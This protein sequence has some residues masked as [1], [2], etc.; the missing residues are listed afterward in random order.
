[1][2]AEP[3]LGAVFDASPNA[4]MVLDR[5]LRYVAVNRAY[6][7]VTEH[8]REQLIG[9]C[10][11]D[12][13][14]HDPA[15]PSNDSAR[16]LVGSLRRVFD[17]GERDV[18]PTIHYRIAIGGVAQDRYWSASHTPLFDGAGRVEYVLQHT[19]DITELHHDRQPGSAAA[20]IQRAEAVQE[21]NRWLHDAFVQAP[22]ALVILRG[23]HHVVEVVNERT[24][25]MWGRTRDQV[26]DRPLFDAL[27]ELA[28]QG[29]RE[30]LDTVWRTRQPYVG[31]EVPIELVRGGNRERLHVT[32]VYQPMFAADGTVDSVIV[33]AVDV[34]QE[35]LARRKVEAAQAELQAIF[36][37]FP[38]ALYAGNA[39]GITRVNDRARE[40]FGYA[41]VDDVKRPFTAVAG[42]VVPRSPETGE[43]LAV[44]ELPFARAL[45][46]LATRRELVLTRADTREDRNVYVSSAPVLVE[47][48]ATGAVVAQIDITEHK[49]SEDEVHKLASV[50]DVTHD[51]VG[52]ADLSGTPT[53]VNA[54]GLALMGLP[55]L[56]AARALKVVEY[57]VPAERA[58]VRDEVLATARRGSYWE[59]ELTFQHARTGEPIPVLQ[60]A[61]PLRDRTGAVVALATVTRDLRAQKLAEAERARLLDAERAARAQAEAAN[62]AK[63]QF[64]AT[65][66]HELRTPLTA[67][68]GWM[69]MLRTGMVAPE[70]QQRALDTVERN[71]RIQAQL[72]DDLLDV[73]R[74]LAG[75]LELDLE[76]VELA[77][78]VAAAVETVRP[79]ADAKGLGIEITV[80]ATPPL[81]GDARRLQQVVWNLLSNAVKFTPRGGLV[82]LRVERGDASSVLTVTDTGAGIAPELLPHVFERFRQADNPSTR[83]AGGLGLGLS[84][85]QHIVAAHH[86]DIRAY[87]DGPG[88]GARFIIALPAAAPSPHRRGSQVD[89]GLDIPAGLSG[90]RVLVVDDETDMREY[91]GALLR[92]AG[93]RVT[94][95]ASACEALA[96]VEHE[97][98]D[99]IVSDIA[100]PEVDGFQLIQR[101][102]ALPDARG[103]RT[104]A[105]ALTAFTRAE[106]RMRAMRAGFQNHVAKPLDPA[107][108]FAVL[109]ACAG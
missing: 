82:T 106:D 77:S 20:V 72:I 39:A 71:A 35:V 98:P 52:I 2:G 94:A 95:V 57:F 34:T 30:L 84:I 41:T 81:I 26:Q 87:S 50:L 97:V 91:V 54:A 1:M 40:L 70:N 90:R 28:G 56:A 38:E 69:Q 78:V 74:I 49:R 64:L 11:I 51:F 22:V 88:T 17:T 79:A 27:P 67:I 37:S 58:R 42:E 104:P 31:T 4:Y 46:G 5:D 36:D 80:E 48:A 29:F 32:F 85:V 12:V 25:A 55:D 53:F 10:L 13:F 47:G 44:D 68:L 8:R 24:C 83:R 63:D 43:P 19:V 92:H 89:S 86:G 75:K 103:G 33:V 101:I 45:R 73:G 9:H 108:L 21:R 105:I 93:M 100:M 6:C 23:P 3:D 15:N 96:A 76:P 18:L 14:P 60:S 102:R 99:L 7:T 16:R 109:V 65:V 59:G 62:L 66:S 107:E 61:F